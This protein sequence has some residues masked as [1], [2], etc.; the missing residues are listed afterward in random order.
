[1]KRFY[2][3]EEHGKIAGVFA[4]LGDM[5]GI[6]PTIL[7]LGAVFLGVATAVAPM[8]ITYIVGWV[9]TPDKKDLPQS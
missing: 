2:R 7:R 8:V 5:F 1:M 3:D 9:I 4:G 6:D